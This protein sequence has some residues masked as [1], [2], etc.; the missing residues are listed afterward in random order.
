MQK[1]YIL[2]VDDDESIRDFVLIALSDE[3]YEVKGASNGLK[4]L[5][6]VS[7]NHQPDLILLDVRMPVMRGKE[8]A[9][10]YLKLTVKHAPIIVLTAALDAASVA[11]AIPNVG[12]LAKPFD[13]DDLYA[14]V[15]KHLAN[16]TNTQA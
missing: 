15:T 14:V 9:E 10:A 6:I 3:G 13:L 8:F 4:A 12:H 2:V 5:E 7:Q 11:S 1:G 16:K